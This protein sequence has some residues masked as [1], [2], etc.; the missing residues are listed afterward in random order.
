MSTN[1]KPPL[2]VAI[3]TL[4][5]EDRLPD[6]LQSI[7][8]ADD[9][10]VVD[11]GSSDATVKIAK[12]Y[13]ARVFQETWRGFGPQK[14]FAIDQCKNDWVLILDADERVPDETREAIIG[15]LDDAQGPVAYSFP[16][17][18]YFSG[19]W[20]RHGGWWPD[21]VIRLCRKDACHYKPQLVHETLIASGPV[22]KIT[23]PIEHFTNRNLHQTMEKMNHYSSASAKELFEKGVPSS[24]LK[25]ISRAIWSFS[26]NYFLRF[27]FM[28]G[29]QGLVIAV[30]NAVIIFFKYAKLLEMQKNS[31]TD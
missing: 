8:F 22:D 19:R 20:I 29:F 17:K 28:D 2:S 30:M 7:A 15:V 26:H 25:A 9:I 18:N 10:V 23:T 16:R 3:I 21:R 14:Q 13:G 27:G 4:N 11:S 24:S 31:N 6:C 1:T 12:Q 5:E